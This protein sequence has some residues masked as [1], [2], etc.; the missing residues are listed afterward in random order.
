MCATKI[1][2]VKNQSIVLKNL[3]GNLNLLFVEEHAK[4]DKRIFFYVL[5]FGWLTIYQKH[6]P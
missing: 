4:F 6:C 5:Y 2:M 3:F 1:A